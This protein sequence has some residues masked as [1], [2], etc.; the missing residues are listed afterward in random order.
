MPLPVPN[1]DDRTFEQ[2]VDEGRSLIPRYSQRWTNH[3]LS[4]PG[5]TLLE[6]F[7]WLTE[8]AIFQLNQLPAA[9]IAQF[10]RLAD[11]CS[12]RAPAT[13]GETLDHT[14]ERILNQLDQSKRAVTADEFEALARAVA[15]AQG[16]RLARTAFTHYHMPVTDAQAAAAQPPVAAL[17]IVVPDE[18]DEPD[19]TNKPGPMPTLALADDIYRGLLP[20]S[21]L[22]TRLHVIGPLYVPVDVT[23]SVVRKPGSGLTKGEIERT[24]RDFLHPLR[25]GVDGNGWPFGRALYRSE[26]YQRLESMAKVDHVE[27]LALATQAPGTLVGGNITIPPQALLARSGAVVVTIKD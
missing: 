20:H 23:V 4:D 16:T 18:P 8:S 15:L 25:G 1:L 3:N 19:H 5:I 24:I 12:E 26:L 10:L 7:A 11:G 6:L 17:L 9:G 13:Q 21:L 22:T 2:L 27:S 14:L